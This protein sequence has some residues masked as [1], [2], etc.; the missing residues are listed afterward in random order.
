MSNSPQ[1]QRSSGQKSTVLKQ[2]LQLKANINKE[3]AK[4]LKELRQDKGRVIITVDKEVAM[5]VLD[6]KYY[7][8]IAKDLL[9][10]GGTYRPLRMD[11]TNKKKSSATYSGPLRLREDWRTPHTKTIK[12]VQAPPPKCSMG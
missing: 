3:E 8:N 6:S 9:V 1:Q 5:V 2:V 7:I 4:A 10:Q 12:P 11:P